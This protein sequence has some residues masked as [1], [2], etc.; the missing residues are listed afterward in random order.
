MKK[1]ER[2]KIRTNNGAIQMWYDV[3]CVGNAWI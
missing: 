2:E 3:S 1:T